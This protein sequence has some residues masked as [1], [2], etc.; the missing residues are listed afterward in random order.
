MKWEK[1]FYRPIMFFAFELV[2]ATGL[3]IDSKRFVFIRHKIIVPTQRL[4]KKWLIWRARTHP[5]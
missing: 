1:L 5:K 2:E 3:L 4:G